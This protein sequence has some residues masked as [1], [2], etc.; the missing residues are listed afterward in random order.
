MYMKYNPKPKYLDR[1]EAS[2]AT[3]RRHALTLILN[4]E[5]QQIERYI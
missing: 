4:V 1:L 5:N 3:A 2:G